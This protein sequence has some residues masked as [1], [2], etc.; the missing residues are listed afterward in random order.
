[1]VINCLADSV[2]S[3]TAG[4]ANYYMNPTYHDVIKNKRMF[5]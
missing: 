3:K 4:I 5:P 2:K 1:M